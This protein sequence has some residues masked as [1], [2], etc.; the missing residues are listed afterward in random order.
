MEGTDHR[1]ITGRMR[2][3]GFAASVSLIAPAGLGPEINGG[4][5]AGFLGAKRRRDMQAAL[6]ALFSDPALVTADMA[7]DLLKARRLDGA[8]DALKAIAAAAFDG[9]RQRIDQTDAWKALASRPL[10]IWGAED[11]IIP[12]AHAARA[13]DALILPQVGHMPHL[14]AAGEVAGALKRHAEA[15]GI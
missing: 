2:R 14:E 13:P 11:K 4:Y 6:G 7:E 1:G 9:D 15:A 10:V 3:D 8:Q 12:A 5:I